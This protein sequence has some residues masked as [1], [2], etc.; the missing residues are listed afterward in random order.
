MRADAL[1]WAIKH[2]SELILKLRIDTNH[3]IEVFVRYFSNVSM[4]DLIE[5]LLPSFRNREYVPAVSI[6]FFMIKGLDEVRMLHKLFFSETTISSTYS[7]QH[8]DRGLIVADE[9]ISETRILVRMLSQH[10][11]YKESSRVYPIY[12]V[13][14]AHYIYRFRILLEEGKG[15]EPLD[16][17]S[18]SAVFKT[19]AL[20]QLRQP[21]R[22]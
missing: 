13:I 1:R 5:V 4:S 19:A 22:V 9:T 6:V 14:K 11:K 7:G 21:S 12:Q 20:N 2:L 15:F 8:L 18:R 17:S 16:R 10:R 3:L